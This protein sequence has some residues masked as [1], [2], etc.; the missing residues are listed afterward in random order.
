MMVK[1]SAPDSPSRVSIVWRKPWI[2]ASLGSLRAIRSRA[3]WS[4]SVNRETGPFPLSLGKAQGKP[5]ADVLA[6]FRNRG[7]EPATEGVG[8]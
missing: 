5:L 3:C 8:F 1:A 6:F 7:T 2:T 4:F